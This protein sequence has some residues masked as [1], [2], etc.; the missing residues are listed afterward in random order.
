MRTVL[1]GVASLCAGLPDGRR[2]ILC[3]ATPG[4]V[5]YPHGLEGREVWVEA[6]VP[7]C[8]CELPVVASNAGA[9]PHADLLLRASHEFLA[10]TVEHLLELGRLDGTE[11]VTA[12][13]LDMARRLGR[14]EGR[15][16][17]VQLPLNREDIADYLGLK[18][19]TVSR[20]LGRI[21]R[22]GLVVFLSPTEFEVPDL[23]NLAARSPIGGRYSSP[24][25]VN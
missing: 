23:D 4:Q 19:E 14:R 20:I 25:L 11:R 9:G 24:H 15:A 7:T 18:A 17:H 3:L 22:S 13:L 16:V 12:F 5:I 21:K 2:Q 8:L 10:V 6:L 1:S